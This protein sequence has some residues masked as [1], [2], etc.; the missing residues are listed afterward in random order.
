MTEKNSESFPTQ[1]QVVIIG[2]GVIGC[3]LTY[4]LT[5][6][7]WRDVVL[8]ERKELTSGTTWHA[9]GLVV[10]GTFT[11]AVMSDM[12]K[13]TRELYQRLEEETGQD[14]GF[15]R[16][17][18]LELA[19][20]QEWLEGLRRAADFGRYNGHVIEEISP[21]EVKKLWPLLKTDDLLAGFFCPD[22]A[23]VNPVDA[24]MALAKGARM[25]GALILEDTKVTTIKKKNGR[26]TGVVTDKGEIEAEYVVNCG[27]MWGRE[28][29][30][31]AGVNVP[32]HAAEHYYLITE[33]I[34]GIHRDLPIMDDPA[35]FAYYREETG[36]LMIG[37][38]EPVA[39]PWGMDGIPREFSSDELAPDWDRMM[40]FLERR[41]AR[42][43]ELLRGRG[44]QLAGYS[45]GWWGWAGNGPMDCGW[46]RAD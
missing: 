28:L 29:G 41:S 12:S 36:G 26:V 22:D 8:L 30:E 46:P 2:G 19:S 23:R 20:S 31:M 18:Y 5:K 39:A 17:G 24:T 4:H 43:E 7:G 44:V 6:L 34:E 25:G 35:R 38:F 33:P 9:A 40:P 14:T 45:A 1:A 21:T 37:L 16:I 10:S 13:Y 42:V 27:G 32:L 15:R 11:S 3:S